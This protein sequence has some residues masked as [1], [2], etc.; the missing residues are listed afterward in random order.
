MVINAGVEFLSEG[1]TEYGSLPDL[2]NAIAVELHKFIVKEK[3]E[4]MTKI[5][6]IDSF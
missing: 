6:L 5:E 4:N 3:G 2:V 1:M